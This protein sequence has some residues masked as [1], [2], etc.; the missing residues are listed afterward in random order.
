MCAPAVR[1]AA[2]WWPTLENNC[3]E[4]V[5]A[6]TDD[7]A[8]VGMSYVLKEEAQLAQIWSAQDQAEQE[9]GR[10]DIADR[11]GVVRQRLE[12]LRAHADTVW[13][14]FVSLTLERVLSGQLHA[15]LDE[16]DA[17][18]QALTL[19]LTEI[20]CEMD[21]I[22]ARIHER[23]RA[24]AGKVAQLEPLAHRTSTQNHLNMM[25]AR[26]EGLEAYLLGKKDVPPESY[27]LHYKRHTNASGDLLYLR[28]RL[29]TTRIALIAANRSR[30]LSE[31]DAMLAGSLLEVEQFKTS[32]ATLAARIE[33]MCELSRY[34][35]MYLEIV[36]GK[37]E[38]ESKLTDSS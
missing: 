17:E 27:D 1:G 29:M 11:F 13:E 23:R 4:T 20:D 14:R 38:Y 28:V 15:F 25:L 18:I 5:I 21:R 26:V 35:L 8:M 24:L 34:W 7:G 37:T 31:F 30:Q 9:Q 3:V 36:V 33:C 12:A 10:Q 19:E 6:E 22:R 16:I 32:L 2:L